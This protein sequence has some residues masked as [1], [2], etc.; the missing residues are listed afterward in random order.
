MA[1]TR[2][3]YILAIGVFGILNTEM[4]IIGILPYIA[5]NYQISLSQAGSLLSIFAL[6][7]AISGPTM[8]L[9]LSKWPRKPLMLLVLAIFT[10]TSILAAWAPN[11]ET[12]F[13]ARLVPALLHPVYCAMAFSLAASSVARK[14]APKAVAKINMG[15]AA[16]MVVGIPISNWLAVHFGLSLAFLFSALVTA[17]VFVMTVLYIPNSLPKETISYGEQ[18][19]VL[20]KPTL[21]LSIVFV[22]ALNGSI[23]GVYNYFVEYALDVSALSTNVVSVTLLV[24]GLMNLVGSGLAGRLLSNQ[25]IR[26]IQGVLLLII[27]IYSSFL[28]GGSQRWLAIGLVTF[29][30]II[31]GISANITQYWIT[32]AA[33]EALNFANGLFLTAANIGVIVGTTLCGLG[34]NQY[35]IGTI[36]YGGIALVVVAIVVFTYQRFYER[37]AYSEA[38]HEI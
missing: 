11:F 22:I 1:S 12:L 18:L 23:Y 14:E 13:V 7:V 32:R 5:E 3:V 30:G 38:V 20:R 33:R 24:Y 16:G 36:M 9:L 27:V 25:A 37:S 17:L 21:W 29:W 4:G 19:R 34:I 10:M 31:A 2:L 26:T 8:P 6:G 15:V 28:V 35:G